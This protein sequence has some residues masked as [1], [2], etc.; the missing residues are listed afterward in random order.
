MLLIFEVA[1]IEC[2]S[3]DSDSYDNGTWVKIK[4]KIKINTSEDGIDPVIAVENIEKDP[5]PTLLMFIHFKIYDNIIFSQHNLYV[6]KYNE[7]NK[8]NLTFYVRLFLFYSSK[9]LMSHFQ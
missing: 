3:G 7:Y 5:T 4:G 2:S 9:T 1:G 6:K 8:N